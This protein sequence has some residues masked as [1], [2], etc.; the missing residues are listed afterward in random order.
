M[1]G[2]SQVEIPTRTRQLVSTEGNLVT[3]TDTTDINCKRYEAD[4][5]YD[6]LGGL[7]N[8]QFK[9]W[10]CKQFYRLGRE[11]VLQLAAIAKADAKTDPRRYFSRLLK[12][13]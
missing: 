12:N 13:S 11:R 5:L 2:V 8:S 7:V 1:Q 10:Y 4:E 6:L 9:A 3:S